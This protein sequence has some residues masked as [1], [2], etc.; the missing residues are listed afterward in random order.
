LRG[1]SRSASC[2]TQ[3]QGLRGQL[4]SGETPESGEGPPPSSAPEAVQAPNSSREVFVS[5]ASQHAAV[6][7][8]VVGT[9]ERAGLKCWIALRAVVPGARRGVFHAGAE[10]SALPQ[11]SP[12][13]RRGDRVCSPDRCFGQVYALD[14]GV[15]RGSRRQTRP[16]SRHLQR[17]GCI[18]RLSG[19]RRRALLGADVPRSSTDHGCSRQKAKGERSGLRP[20][21][22][23]GSLAA[24]RPPCQ[25]AVALWAE[26]GTL[27]SAR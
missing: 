17:R 19:P 18:R 23:L 7:D 5:Y 10:R 6:A 24:R 13:S 21:S 27:C 9:L 1:R 12:C 15:E 3:E 25:A 20:R 8:A 2:G 14:L 26:C 4:M 16:R 22:A 11:P